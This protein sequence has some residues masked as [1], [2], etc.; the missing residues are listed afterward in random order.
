ME[1]DIDLFCK[2]QKQVDRAK[3]L[4]ATINLCSE[5]IELIL[6]KVDRTGIES[7]INLRG[8]TGQN[9]E[10]LKEMLDTRAQKMKDDWLPEFKKL[11][12]SAAEGIWGLDLTKLDHAVLEVGP[13]STAKHYQLRWCFDDLMAAAKFISD[14]SNP[15]LNKD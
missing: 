11:A 10:A 12:N 6:F 1:V 2:F 9:H 13:T 3:D 5:A 4:F 15:D 8:Y 14:D 7:V